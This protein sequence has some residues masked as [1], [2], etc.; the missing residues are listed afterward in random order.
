LLPNFRPQW[1]ARK[2]AQEL[3]SNYQANGLTFADVESGRF[4]RLARI[5]EL[6]QDS[7]VDGRL[8]WLPQ[9]KEACVGA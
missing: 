5:R 1:D 3:Y 7:R 6:M 8:R 9:L 2:G 4:T